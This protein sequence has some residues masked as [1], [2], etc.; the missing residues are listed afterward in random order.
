MDP[1]VH[2][3]P[4]DRTRPRPGAAPGR[5]GLLGPARLCPAELSPTLAALLDTARSLRSFPGLVISSPVESVTRWS[6][7]LARVISPMPASS[8]AF[9]HCVSIAK[10]AL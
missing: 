3:A 10:V 7:I 2:R 6:A 1:P 4:Q 8:S 5:R 9:F